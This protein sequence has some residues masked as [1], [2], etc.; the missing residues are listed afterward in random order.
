MEAK[1]VLTI[2]DMVVSIVAVVV[3]VPFCFVVVDNDDD[4]GVVSVGSCCW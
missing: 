4:D 3:V 2:C 1:P